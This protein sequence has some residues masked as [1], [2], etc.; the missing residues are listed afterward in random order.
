[1]CGRGA[2]Q[3]EYGMVFSSFRL[4]LILRR[5]SRIERFGCSKTGVRKLV[6]TIHMAVVKRE[7][8]SVSVHRL[9]VWPV[10]KASS[11]FDLSCF[12][13]VAGS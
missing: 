12:E 3:G 7:G 5:K 9:K 10:R 1:M 6:V 2:T 4:R 11:E 13:N 8:V